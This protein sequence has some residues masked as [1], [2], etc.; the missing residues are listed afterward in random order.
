MAPLPVDKLAASEPDDFKF[1]DID[2]DDGGSVSIRLDTPEMAAG[3]APY[4]YRPGIFVGELPAGMQ[5]EKVFTDWKHAG[6]SEEFTSAFVP[7][8]RALFAEAEKYAEQQLVLPGMAHDAFE[9]LGLLIPSRAIWRL[10]QTFGGPAQTIGAP[11]RIFLQVQLDVGEDVDE[12][13]ME[14]IEYFI[15]YLD[16][17][18]ALDIIHAAAVET[19]QE[20]IEPAKTRVQKEKKIASMREE[21]QVKLMSIPLK[22]LLSLATNMKGPSNMLADVNDALYTISYI[23]RQS[24]SADPLLQ[25]GQRSLPE[26]ISGDTTT[27][28]QVQEWIKGL[29]EI[30]DKLNRGE[31][32]A[33]DPHTAAQADQQTGE[34]YYI[35]SFRFREAFAAVGPTGRPDIKRAEDEIQLPYFFLPQ[36]LRGELRS[37]WGALKDLIPNMINKM[38][39]MAMTYSGDEYQ[40]VSYYTTP[41][42][43][44]MAGADWLPEWWVPLMYKYEFLDPEMKIEDEILDVLK[45]TQAKRAQE[46]EPQKKLELKEAYNLLDK[47]DILIGE[48]PRT[49]AWKKYLKK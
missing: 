14:E 33:F 32:T 7:K 46:A 42:N 10:E 17:Q 22:E 15:K 19:F 18:E 44:E 3:G 35:D 30:L 31:I 48:Q 9:V 16:R 20:A 45:Q 49:E 11:A 13:G 1:W 36:S 40:R 4:K 43:Q 38:Q 29:D 6:H 27:A 28:A 5:L 39:D 8:I 34:L 47:I 37:L 2:V 12:T 21:L 24:D 25:Y 41:N 26:G 23:S